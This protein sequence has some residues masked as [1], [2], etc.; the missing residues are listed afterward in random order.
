MARSPRRRVSSAQS[1]TRTMVKYIGSKRALLDAIIRT[2]KAAHSPGTFLDLFSGTSRVGHAM[3]GLGWRVLAND[4]NAY[5][6]TLARCYVQADREDVVEDAT[7]LIR[8]LNALPGRPGYFTETYCIRSR[9]FHPKNGER[10]DAIRD[11]IAAKCLAEEL[12]AVLLVS[13]MEAADRVDSTTGLQMAY[14]KEWAP[15]ALN[16]LCLRLPDVLPRARA[17]KGQA[18]MLDALEAARRLEG[19][20]A[21]LDPPYNQHSYLSNYHIWETLVLWDRPEVYGVACKRVDCRN[22]KSPFNSRKNFLPAFRSVL[23]EVRARVVIISFNN[24]GFVNRAAMEALLEDVFGPEANIRVVEQ[25]Y[26]RYVGA[27]IGIYN[28]EGR[29]V[30]RVSHLRNREYLYVVDRD[31]LLSDAVP[32]DEAQ[33]QRSLFGPEDLLQGTGE[34]LPDVDESVPAVPGLR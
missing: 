20:V 34:D 17:G 3:K 33:P 11:A 24:E 22:R 4:H 15:R 16:D 25:D 10:I 31:G 7:R 28:P 23:E 12:E 8:E 13:L 21:Y 30:G 1:R 6:A 18:F 14:L 26:K 9:F 5:A 2:V 19:D 27:Q 32:G 29:K